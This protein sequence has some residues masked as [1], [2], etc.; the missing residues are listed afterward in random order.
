MGEQA[1]DLGNLAIFCTLLT[2]QTDTDIKISCVFIPPLAK[3][4][5]DAL[6][7]CMLYDSV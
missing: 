2:E 6:V 4:Q 5:N 1:S 3:K 7:D